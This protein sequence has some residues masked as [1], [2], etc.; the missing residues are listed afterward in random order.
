MT[1]W[2]PHSQVG[3]SVA[4]PL[5][6]P[7]LVVA[8]VASIL[9]SRSKSASSGQVPFTNRLMLPLNRGFKVTEPCLFGSHSR[10]GIKIVIEFKEL[11]I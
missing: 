11:N 10:C 3:E 6:L 4:D 9:F 5:L 1:R 2:D 8:K 7:V